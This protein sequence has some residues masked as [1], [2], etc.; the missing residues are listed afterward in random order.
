MR[1][2]RI[3]SFLAPRQER[4]QHVIKGLKRIVETVS[5]EDDHE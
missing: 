3:T 4:C 5:G 2:D 1:L